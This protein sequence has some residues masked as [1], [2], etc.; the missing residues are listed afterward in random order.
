MVRLLFLL[1]VLVAGIALGPL[2]AGHQ[3]AVLIQT[4]NYDIKMS[5]TGLA[6]SIALLVIVLFCLEMGA[7]P[8]F[9]H[10]RPHQGLVYRS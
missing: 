2:L 4:D 9:P 8:P 6:I 5:V 7:A 1:V 3:G 10:Q